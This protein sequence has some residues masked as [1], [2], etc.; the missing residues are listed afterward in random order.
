MRR[1]LYLY[2][3]PSSFL[4]LHPSQPFEDIVNSTMNSM[5]WTNSTWWP[6]GCS[7][8]D[9]RAVRGAAT[10]HQDTSLLLHICL[11]YAVLASAVAF[12]SYGAAFWITSWFRHL[13]ACFYGCQHYER[14]VRAKCHGTLA[15]RAHADTHR[16]AGV[17]WFSATLQV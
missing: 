7:C 4:F 2:P 5:L 17:P 10:G 6:S 9:L 13:L 15:Y 3:L 12:S 1:P 16:Q 14:T 11:S 8:A